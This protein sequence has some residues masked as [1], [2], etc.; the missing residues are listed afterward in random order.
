MSSSST[1]SGIASVAPARSPA[2]HASHIGRSSVA[3]A[4]PLVERGVDRARSG[5]RRSSAGRG[6][7]RRRGPRSAA[8]RSGRRSPCPRPTIGRD[9]PHVVGREPV[10]DRAVAL[11]ARRA[12]ASPGAARRRGSAAAASTRTPSRKPFTENVSYVCGHLLAR[13][14]GA[15]EAQRVAHVV[16]RPVERD[17]VPPL[18]DHVRRRADAD[19]RRGP[20]RLR[21][22]SRSSARAARDRGCRRGRRPGRA[23][24]SG[25][26]AAASASDGERVVRVRPRSTR[27]R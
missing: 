6:G 15:Q 21:R 11:A 25:V 8:R 5:T 22:G 24:G 27:C 4:D 13:E 17:A 9:G 16:V 26:H 23:A 12:A 20:A 14:R 10:D 7:G 18:D 1:S 3:A 2:F 19:A